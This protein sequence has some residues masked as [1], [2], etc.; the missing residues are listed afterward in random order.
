[1]ENLKDTMEK[2]KNPFNIYVLWHPDY[3]DGSKFKATLKDQNKNA[4]SKAKITITINGR[5]Y[6]KTTDS[7]GVASLDINLWS[8][9]YIVLTNF[10]R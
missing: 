2:V 7:K 6:E 1:M 10:L 5:S 4:I 3:K 8:G 9:N